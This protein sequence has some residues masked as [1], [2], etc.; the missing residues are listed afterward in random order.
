MRAFAGRFRTKG[1]FDL[2]SVNGMVT[3]AAVQAFGG[4]PVHLHPTAARGFF[5]LSKPKDG[6]A[7]VKH[8]VADWAID[9][10]NL[11]ADYPWVRRPRSGKLD[12]S[13]YDMTDAYLLARAAAFK[14]GLENKPPLPLHVKELR[15]EGQDASETVLGPSH[16]SV[17]LVR[18]TDWTRD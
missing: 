2:A 10:L 13:C 6:S 1:L 16:A 7:H 15:Y 11:P 17:T 14:A 12:E 4:T 9:Q 18:E 5:S 8:V 3:F